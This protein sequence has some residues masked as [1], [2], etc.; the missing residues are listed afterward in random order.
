MQPVQI[1]DTTLRDGTQAEDFNL[2]LED[3]IRIALK[4]DDLG[5]HYIEGG[6][7]GSNPRDVG[8][9]EEIQHYQL[10]TA[11]IAAF[12]ATHHPRKTAGAD[13]NLQALIAAKTPVVTIFGKSWTIHVRDALHTTLEHN[14]ELIH[15]SLAYLRPH[16]ETLFYDAEHFFDGFRADPEYALATLGKA[17]EGRADCLVL[18][19]TNG[20]NIPNTIREAM[21]V[22][23]DRFPGVPLGIHAHNDADVAVANSLVAVEM[24]AVQVQGTINGV[25]ERCG[26]ANLCSII[27]NL[28]LKMERPASPPTSS[29]NC[30]KPAVLSWNWLMFSPI[31]ISPMWD[32]VPLPTRAA[33]TSARWNGIPKPMNMSTPSWWVIGV[34]FWFPTCLVE[35]PSNARPRIMV[36]SFQHPIRWLCKFWRNS[37]TWR[38]KGF[39]FEAAEASFELLLNKAMGRRKQYFELLGFR[40]MDQKLQGRQRTGG[41]SHDP[42]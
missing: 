26:N 38:T 24:G 25:G 4:L 7:P 10:K 34:E 23:K 12:G 6:W 22:V 37:R 32:A 19:D 20:G 15:D 13:A 42:H 41:R 8:F 33:F 28:C 9:F 2:S 5:I 30:A 1:Y 16:V 35:P 40:V 36:L 29:R 31:G 11:K 27:A 39:Q 3:K 21:A 18:C 14:L 17:I